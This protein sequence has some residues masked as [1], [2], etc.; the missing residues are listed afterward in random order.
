MLW[1]SGPKRLARLTV[2]LLL[3]AVAVSACEIARASP[4]MDIN[5]IGTAVASTLEAESADEAQPSAI[6]T[7]TAS[8]QRTPVQTSGPTSTRTATRTPSS[9]PRPV[10]TDTRI[11]EGCP[12]GCTYPKAGCVIKGNISI[13]TGERIYHLPGQQYY[14]QTIIRPEYGER[15]FCTEAEAIANGWRKS[16]R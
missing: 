1:Q 15:W 11:P 12:D 16:K 7:E 9:T 14:D 2:G 8:P 10:P 5:Q 3:G 13:D 6:P 4:T